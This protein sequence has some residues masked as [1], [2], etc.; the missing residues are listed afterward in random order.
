MEVGAPWVRS[1]PVQSV[2]SRGIT[3]LTDSVL[4]TRAF[5][6]TCPGVV[7]WNILKFGDSEFVYIG[8]PC[9]FRMSNYLLRVFYS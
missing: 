5:P 6:N 1:S 7:Q 4:H 3:L 2:S 8:L 9:A